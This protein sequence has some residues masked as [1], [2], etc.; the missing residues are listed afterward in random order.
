MQYSLCVRVGHSD[1]EERGGIA[2]YEVPVTGT[3]SSIPYWRKRG[4]FAK[5]VLSSQ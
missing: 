1:P 3:A 2:P 5:R 4:I